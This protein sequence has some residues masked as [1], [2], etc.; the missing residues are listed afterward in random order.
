MV[1][2][3]LCPTSFVCLF[4]GVIGVDV[5]IMIDYLSF[6]ACTNHPSPTSLP[7]PAWD[8]PFGSN[9]QGRLPPLRD[10]FVN[11]HVCFCSSGLVLSEGRL[12][13]LWIGCCSGNNIL[14]KRAQALAAGPLLL[15]YQA[16][17]PPHGGFS[18]PE[19]HESDQRE[20]TSLTALKGR[21]RGDFKFSSQNTQPR[22][23][24]AKVNAPSTG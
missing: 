22:K 10:S 23:Q 12:I 24:Q 20:R 21:S 18:L 8:A 9:F 16:E 13:F 15:A 1:S 14:I 5:N 7:L 19:V 3:K 17:F 6:D 11:A 4:V 2:Y